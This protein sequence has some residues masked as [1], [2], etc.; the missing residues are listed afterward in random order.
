VKSRHADVTKHH[1]IPYGEQL[2]RCLGGAIGWS[3]LA[4]DLYANDIIQSR[5]SLL[6]YVFSTEVTGWHAL[7]NRAHPNAR[8][9][10]KLL[11][12]KRVFAETMVEEGFPVIQDFTQ[13]TSDDPLRFSEQ[14][15]ADQG[16]V[17]CKLNSGNQALHAFAA[18]WVDGKLKGR[19]QTGEI[20][21]TPA[22]VDDAWKTLASLGAA[23]V[24]PRLTNHPDVLA[25]SK[26][27]RIANLR[28]ITRGNRIGAATFTL[29]TSDEK[30]S[31][32]W[33]DIQPDTGHPYLPADIYT[34]YHPKLDTIQP[35]ADMAPQI[36]PFWDEICADSLRAHENEFDL[37]AIAWDWA[38]TPDGP[39]LLEGNSG[40]GLQDWQLQSGSLLLPFEGKRNH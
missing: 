13:P 37:W 31:E 20:L 14:F 6:S 8:A 9:S 33:L 38:I 11:G 2:R 25:M 29:Y 10:Q 17:F 16:A 40:W 3:I 35:L 21:D 28:I 27:D 26:S 15:R 1:G 32:Y 12:D 34:A 36:I 4:N 22:Q 24:Q 30:G 5:A 7:Q 19:L 18:Y 39:V 23:I